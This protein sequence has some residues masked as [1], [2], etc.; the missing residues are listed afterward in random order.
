[1]KRT[2]FLCGGIALVCVASLPFWAVGQSSNEWYRQ[3][4]FE[5]PIESEQSDNVELP[6]ALPTSSEEK[7]IRLNYIRGT[8]DRILNDLAKASEK[9]LVVHHRPRGTFSRTDFRKYTPDEAIRILNESLQDQGCRILKN[10]KFLTVI[11]AQLSRPRYTRRNFQPEAQQAEEQYEPQ[12]FDPSNDQPIRS[13]SH[14]RSI[15]TEQELGAFVGNNH[16]RQV[17]LRQVFTYS[18]ANQTATAVAKE[19]H[20]HWM[21]RSK[22]VNEGPEGLPAFEVYEIESGKKNAGK[23]IVLTAGIDTE[24]N[25]LVVEATEKAGKEFIKLANAL[26]RREGS[27]S[28]Q[29]DRSR[30]ENRIRLAEKVKAMAT[31]FQ[32]AKGKSP[33]R[34][35]LSMQ[36]FA[37][38]SQPKQNNYNPAVMNEGMPEETSQA[39]KRKSLRLTIQSRCHH[40]WKLSKGMSRLK[41]S[42]N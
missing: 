25:R 3:A 8:W 14:K 35:S 13:A 40:C 31:V 7:T 41:G 9:T 19:M 2:S 33:S 26:D 27:E 5:T 22:L 30:F 39:T 12:K 42:T 24:R 11:S 4:E 36:T 32:K 28:D 18:L 16:K 15:P 17:D 23:K 1:M 6:S 34:R 38:N 29:V 37:Q 20:H 10:E 21:E